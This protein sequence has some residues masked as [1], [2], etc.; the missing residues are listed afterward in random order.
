MTRWAFRSMRH[1]KSDNQKNWWPA[2]CGV[3]IADWEMI[4]FIILFINLLFA[5]GTFSGQEIYLTTY[6]KS[7]VEE[8]YRSFV[9]VTVAILQCKNSP[10]QAKV[11]HSKS[12]LTKSKYYQQNVKASKVTVIIMQSGLCQCLIIISNI[13][14]LACKQQ[15]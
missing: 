8:I 2:K 11:L 10:W 7:V 14:A 1:K 6:S 9:L 12:N 4:D 5:Q 15:L 13:D 3:I